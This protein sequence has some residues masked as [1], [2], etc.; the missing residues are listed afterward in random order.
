MKRKLI[1][2]LVATFVVLIVVGTAM[3]FA[4]Y[5][6]T[7]KSSSMAYV[8]NGLVLSYKI[9]NETNVEEYNIKDVVFFDVDST[10]E[11]KYFTRS[12]VKLTL[13]ISNYSLTPVDLTVKQ[14]IQPF[15]LSNSIEGNV[16]T[17]YKYEKANVNRDTDFTAAEYYVFDNVE[18]YS[19]K[20][21]YAA[22]N[23]YFTKEAFVT[24]TITVEDSKIKSISS[25][26]ENSSPL[27]TTIDNAGTSFVVG[28]YQEATNLTKDAFNAGV[29]YTLADNKYSIAKTFNSETD[30]YEVN[31]MAYVGGITMSETSITNALITTTGAYVSCVITDTELAD[32][33]SYS[34]SLNQYIAANNLKNDFSTTTALTASTGH[35]LSGGT[36]RIYLY[37]FGIQLFD[38][39]TSNFLE[40]SRN[41]YP[42]SLII[43]ATQA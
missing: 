6:N 14:N 12:A 19:K 33:S 34:G 26:D 24:S 11:G 17:I 20:T 28:K 3:T 13:D 37:M 42:F 7:N 31:T 21:A 10:K 41:V 18:G 43:T 27:I 36:K 32:N 1:F 22:G 29:Y 2:N 30:Y 5:T 38:N 8:S 15:T 4:W 9:E 16:M 23:T 35:G 39:A 40:N 25:V